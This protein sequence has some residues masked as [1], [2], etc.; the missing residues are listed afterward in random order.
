MTLLEILL[1]LSLIVMLLAGVYIFY[2]NT[3]RA[4]ESAD[5]LTKDVALTRFVLERMANDIRHAAAFTPG[6]GVGLTGDRH[7]ITL[8]RY[9][10]PETDV[11]AEYDPD[12][13]NLPPAKADLRKITYSLLIDDEHVDENGDP[14]VHGL[15]TTRQ[16]TLNQVVVFADE[17]DGGGGGFDLDRDEKGGQTVQDAEI[18]SGLETELM[19]PEIKYLEFMYFDGAEWA[20][21][22]IG[23]DKK[24]NSLP[25]AV[26]ITVG[27][28]PVTPE[29]EEF[30][31]SVLETMDKEARE[32]L[33]KEHPDRFALI[34]R[35][36]QADRFLNSRIVR[37]KNSFGGS[38]GGFGTSGDIGRGLGSGGFGGGMR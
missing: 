25:Q 11:F 7:Q 20:P 19:A 18:P 33:E 26:M 37:A 1:A 2:V 12:L 38:S 8:Y 4:R 27:R 16:Q 23:G 31:V 15:W 22:W 30:D 34:V 14:I 3:M 24:E 35:L 10:M 17:G 29:E 9:V 13:G 5:L 21:E 36:P 28:I 6:F 32:E